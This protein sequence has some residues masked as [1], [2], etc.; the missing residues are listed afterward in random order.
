MPEAAIKHGSAAT[1]RPRLG[2]GARYMVLEAGPR[3]V[4]E[5]RTS[6]C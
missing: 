5:P 2:I 6:D 1:R 4:P 3:T